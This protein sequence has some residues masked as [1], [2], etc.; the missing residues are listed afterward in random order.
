MGLKGIPRYHTALTNM[1]QEYTSR[2]GFVA[3]VSGA[4]PALSAFTPAGG[5]GATDLDAAS[6]KAGG[7]GLYDF[8]LARTWLGLLG[9][10]FKVLQASYS[11]SGAVYGDVTV[12]NSTTA[13]GTGTAPKVRVTFRNAAGA[14]VDLA[15]GDTVFG[16]L[17][18]MLRKQ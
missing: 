4:L 17:T 15:A 11:A 5:G 12:D 10:E 14:A 9:W 13:F 1:Q 18:F 6:V 16:A 8:F 7:T 3:G 2:F